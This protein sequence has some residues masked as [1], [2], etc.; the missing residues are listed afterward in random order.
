M[1]T[2]TRYCSYFSQ[3]QLLRLPDMVHIFFFFCL[4]IYFWCKLLEKNLNNLTNPYMA[5]KNLK[6]T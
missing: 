2:T 6:N 5:F 1:A 4:E 3:F